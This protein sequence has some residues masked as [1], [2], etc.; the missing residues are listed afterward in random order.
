[1]HFVF[2][3]GQ[4][5]LSSDNLSYL[6]GLGQVLAHFSYLFGLDH[7]ILTIAAGWSNNIILG[8]II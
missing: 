6:F 3:F 5:G 7:V 1:M 8:W 2:G 4:A